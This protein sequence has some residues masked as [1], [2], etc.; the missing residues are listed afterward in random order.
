MNQQKTMSHINGL[1][2]H[3]LMEYLKGSIY[4]LNHSTL[5]HEEYLL[6]QECVDRALHR[7]ESESKLLALPYRISL[8]DY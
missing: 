7:L 6:H 4:T 8:A 1:S 5:S 3:S 2:L